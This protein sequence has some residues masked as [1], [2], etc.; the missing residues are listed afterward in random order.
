MQALFSLLHS[1][2]VTTASLYVHSF[3]DINNELLDE[4]NLE[5]FE[6]TEISTA[7]LVR[8]HPELMKRYDIEDH[9]EL[10][11]LLR[12]I[13][14]ERS[15]H[16]FH[17]GRMPMICF[18]KFDRDKM[19][20]EFLN[21]HS[22]IGM[23][24]LCELM[25][26]EYGYDPMVTRGNY[27]K[28]IMEYY[29]NGVFS[30]EQKVMPKERKDALEKALKDDFYYIDEIRDIYLNLYPDA[31]EDEVNA[32]NLKNMGFIILSRYALQN[33]PSLESYYIDLLTRNDIT[34]LTPIRRRHAYIQMF[35]AVLVRL[36][37]DLTIV[38][39][40]PNKLI[41]FKKLQ[42]SGITKDE[43][44]DYCQEVYEFVEDNAYFSFESIQADGF[45]TKLY[46]LGF[47]GWFYANLLISDDRFS[48]TSVMGNI[49][50]YKGNREIS[51]K[52]FLSDLIKKHRIIDAYDLENE[53]ENKY[54]CKIAEHK[55]FL[56][57]IN[58]TDIYYDSN[59]DR[60]YGNI[61][62]YYNELEKT[63][64]L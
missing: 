3:A 24:D 20:R 55:Y 22:P 58:D 46:D 45:E 61:E 33:Y 4:L 44:F 19:I 41:T 54:G 18:G 23:D 2:L 60:L 56:Y 14:P 49:I 13:V 17:C 35:S 25:E 59:L 28:C 7:K 62:L 8:D 39:F 9:Y 53:L 37:K 47:S 43:I 40:E 52:S 29:H 1:P 51:I 30:V 16:D 26:E 10:H 34:D 32:Y 5:A 57:K 50:F 27:L 15:Y 21:D 63:E 48:Y 31:D 36:K 12:K 38:E 42:T 6:N 64:D 11:N